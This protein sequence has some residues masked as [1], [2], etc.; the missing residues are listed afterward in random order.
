MAIPG[1]GNNAI[2]I[3]LAASVQL[4]YSV[5]TWRFA[6]AAEWVLLLGLCIGWTK[7]LHS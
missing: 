3:R 2:R 7:I 1:L 5:C 6:D 4:G